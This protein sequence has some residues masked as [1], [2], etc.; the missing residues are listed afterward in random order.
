MSC[1]ITDKFLYQYAYSK[2]EIDDLISR[3]PG[4]Q[5]P[6]GNPGETGPQGPAGATGATGP[7]GPAGPGFE[8]SEI[9][10]TADENGTFVEDFY[11]RA[12]NMS[13]SGYN[14]SHYGVGSN[15]LEVLQ[16]GTYIIYANLV[17]TVSAAAMADC[18][19][20]LMR[21]NNSTSSEVSIEE[22]RR[23]GTG[24]TGGRMFIPGLLFN[25]GA[26]DR[27]YLDYYMSEVKAISSL[28]LRVVRLK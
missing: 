24:M 9:F 5:G 3:N 4:P 7:Q 8:V 6:Q 18:R 21:Y 15:Y 16:A 25:L 26:N 13:A 12:V 17:I 27:L 19:F 11:N 23:V 22:D 10:A 1:F 20:R 2:Q 28:R 14:G